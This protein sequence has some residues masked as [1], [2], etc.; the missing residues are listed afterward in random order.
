M[1]LADLEMEPQSGI[2]SEVVLTTETPTASLTR[3]FTFLFFSGISVGFAIFS[4]FALPPI[5]FIRLCGSAFIQLTFLSL[6]LFTLMIRRGTWTIDSEGIWYQPC[7]GRVRYLAWS[8]VERVQ[9]NRRFIIFQGESDKILLDMEQFPKNCRA[10]AI[11]AIE[12]HLSS[13]FDLKPVVLEGPSSWTRL[14][15]V[16]AISSA[17]V[18]AV[19]AVLI[20]ALR[21]F[22]EADRTIGKIFAG[23]IFVM[24][25]GPMIYG[26]FLAQARER[27]VREKHP[28]WPWR[29]RRSKSKSTTSIDREF[30]LV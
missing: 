27:T 20:L 24:L 6:A 14:A 16:G 7:L 13:D 8:S 23:P 19:F 11:A 2:S 10:P 25:F 30:E 1:N 15:I 12:T 3:I 28:H 22:P 5:D 9:W 17:L 29:I 18:L 4:L 26:A 21:T